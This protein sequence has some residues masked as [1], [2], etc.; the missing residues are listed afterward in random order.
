M[1][2]KIEAIVDG[3]GL[4]E[5]K[6]FKC[7]GQIITDDGKCDNDIERRIAIAR[8]AFIN[9]KDVLTMLYTQTKTGYMN[10]A[11]KVLYIIN[12]IICMLREE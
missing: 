12:V 1:K 9:M 5:E 11:S 4:G 6:D 7:L 2:N 8:S 10:K 3:R